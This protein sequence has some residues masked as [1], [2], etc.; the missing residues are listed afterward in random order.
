MP[1]KG[2]RSITLSE[3]VY[4]SI[5]GKARLYGTSAPELIK[6]M[7][8][9]D[10]LLRRR[11][12]AGVA[13]RPSSWQ[14]T[15]DSFEKWLS[16][17]RGLSQD[18]I[19]RYSAEVR[20]CPFEPESFIGEYRR[21]RVVAFRLYAHY[22]YQTGQMGMEDRQ[23]WLE[24]LKLKP[25]NAPG[26]VE[27]KEADVRA[28]MQQPH[29]PLVDVLYYSGVRVTEAYRLCKDP[30]SFEQLEGFRRHSVGWA[31]GPK[32]C[33]YAYLP[34]WVELKTAFGCRPEFLSLRVKM[35]PKLLRKFFYRVAKRVALEARADPAVADFYQSRIS[36]LSVGERHYGELRREAD[37]LYTKVA[38]EL[39]RLSG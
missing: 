36:R 24:L 39:R 7:V 6:T 33:D 3:D 12:I 23:R 32:R 25:Q 34:D 4:N 1:R 30:H 26:E 31:R 38:E 29:D 21:W 9:G 13:S 16:S 22:L 10:F 18:T 37:A 8:E 5:V 28:L 11:K 19:V 27:V 20:A 35:R 14:N 17:R 2:Y 15:I